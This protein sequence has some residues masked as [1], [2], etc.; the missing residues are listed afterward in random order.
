MADRSTTMATR[1][2]L[3]LHLPGGALLAKVVVRY[4]KHGQGYGL[5]FINLKP[6]DKKR[7]KAYCSFLEELASPDSRRDADRSS[8]FL[9]LMRPAGA[10]SPR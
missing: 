1:G 8:A 2:D 5:E 6:Q 4:P 3:I 7:L 10:A 9:A